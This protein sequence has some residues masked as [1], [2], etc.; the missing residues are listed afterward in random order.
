[1]NKKILTLLFVFFV[2][3]SMA[4]VYAEGLESHDFGQFKMDIPIA[5]NGEIDETS[6]GTGNHPIYAIPNSDS[7]LFCYVDYFNTS[8]VNGTKNVTEYVL[9]K[10]KEN[11]TVT[12]ENGTATWFYDDTQDNGYLISSDDDTK[13]LLIQGNDIY[14]QD[15]VN[16]VEF[17]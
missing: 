12:I 13:A 3:I 7:T 4:T 15:A 1:M 16:S 6:G 10:I 5:P 8:H 9:N 14:L 17:K 2:A 11:Y